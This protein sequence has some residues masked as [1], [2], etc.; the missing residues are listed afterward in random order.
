VVD[1]AATLAAGANHRDDCPVI[2][3]D[4]ARFAVDDAEP[5]VTAAFACPYCLEAPSSTVFN[6]EE[7]NGSAVLC[8]CLH[9]RASWVVAVNTGQALRLA[10]APPTELN[11]EPA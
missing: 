11:L 6:L 2:L 5:L 7:P 3:T 9:C 10:I 8:R 4:S 1:R